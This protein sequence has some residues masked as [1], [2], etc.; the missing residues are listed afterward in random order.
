MI[1]AL[2]WER[3][4]K[5]RF[6]GFGVPGR[7]RGCGGVRRDAAET[8]FITELIGAAAEPAEA[9]CAAGSEA[10]EPDVVF[11]RKALTGPCLTSRLSLL[12]KSTSSVSRSFQF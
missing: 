6:S 2:A 7:G 3:R 8:V 9:A 10:A 12:D 5:G 11:A 1:E 4:A